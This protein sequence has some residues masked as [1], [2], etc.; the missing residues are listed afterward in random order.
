MHIGKKCLIEIRHRMPPFEKFSVPMF[1]RSEKG[2]DANNASLYP[3]LLYHKSHVDGRLALPYANVYHKFRAGG[4]GEPTQRGVISIPAVRI[5]SDGRRE[6][7]PD[8][9]A[10]K[11]SHYLLL[12]TQV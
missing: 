10:I 3:G 2:I 9:C 7:V 5:G 8:V 6:S 1:E 12:E 4:G 11:S